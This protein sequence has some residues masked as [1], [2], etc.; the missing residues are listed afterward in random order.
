MQRRSERTLR[1]NRDAGGTRLAGAYPVY[2]SNVGWASAYLGQPDASQYLA[3]LKLMQ[4]LMMVCGLL[5]ATQVPNLARWM[6]A[7]EPR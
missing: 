5:G 1:I 2:N 6:A 3:T 4:V 7:G